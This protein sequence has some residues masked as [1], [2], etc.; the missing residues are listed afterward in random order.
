MPVGAE[1]VLQ[2]FPDDVHRDVELE[3]VCEENGNSDHEFD[4]LGQ[5]ERG[6]F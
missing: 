3:G 2:G 1:V 6:K 4:G 5:A